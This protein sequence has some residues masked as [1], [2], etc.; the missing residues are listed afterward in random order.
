MIPIYLYTFL[1]LILLITVTKT[2][3]VYEGIIVKNKNPINGL[4]AILAI[5]VMYS[6]TYKELYVNS[7]MEW[8]YTQK[9]YFEYI[10]WGN[11]AI[12]AGKIGVAIFFMISGYL[13]YSLLNKE[14]F[15]STLFFKQRLKRIF[16][17]YFFVISFC[18]LYNFIV[19]SNINVLDIILPYIKWILF[20]GEDSTL[21]LMSMT[22]G[23]EWTLKI[24][25][26]MYLT[27]PTLFYTFHNLHNKIIKHLLIIFAI[28]F[29]F[30]IGYVLRIYFEFY[31][32]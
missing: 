14:K 9:Q 15:N 20:F 32:D 10:G 13:F 11:Q 26:L 23:V 17:L 2:H 3:Q 28:L 31:I 21:K 25:I 6:H 16:P 8:I 4:R 1:F 30:L 12:N 7:D 18:V 22:S 5:L 19:L 27:I 24:E 29:V